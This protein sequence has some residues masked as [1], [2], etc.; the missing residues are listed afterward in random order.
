MGTNVLPL[1]SA[2]VQTVA[3]RAPEQLPQFSSKQS[4]AAAPD[5]GNAVSVVNARDSGLASQQHQPDE[6][7]LNE[8]L[9]KLNNHVSLFN[10]DL[11]FTTDKDTNTPVVR[12]VDRVTKDVI[13]QIP[14]KEAVKLAQALEDLQGLL[15]RDKA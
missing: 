10:S 15:I 11:E 8:S 1:V 9:E 7:T 3:G 6:K 4:S 12:V 14:S 2:A 13:R 5:T